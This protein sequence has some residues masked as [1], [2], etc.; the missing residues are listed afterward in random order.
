MHN[1]HY[2]EDQAKS[3]LDSDVKDQNIGT[4]RALSRAESEKLEDK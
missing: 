3:F 4:V 1:I 2:A